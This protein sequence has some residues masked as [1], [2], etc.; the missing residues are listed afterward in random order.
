MHVAPY[1]PQSRACYSAEH[2]LMSRARTSLEEAGDN[3]GFGDEVK[4]TW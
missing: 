3:E 2:A 4:G 1:E